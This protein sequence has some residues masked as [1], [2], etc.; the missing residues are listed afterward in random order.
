[1]RVIYCGSHP[2]VVSA[3]W[4][5]KAVRLGKHVTVTDTIGKELVARGD[6]VE[7][8]P[9]PAVKPVDKTKRG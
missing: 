8:V 4:K 2:E 6:F 1:M 3:A 9:E 7:F 5:G